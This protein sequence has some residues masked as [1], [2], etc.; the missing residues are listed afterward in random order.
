MRAAL[1]VVLAQTAAAWYGA[2]FIWTMQMLNYPLLSRVGEPSFSA[3]ETAH[4]Q[5]FVV[6]VA[7]GVVVAL[8]TTVLLF[9]VRPP[10]IPIAAPIASATLIVAIIVSTVLFQAP[11]HG[12]LA[13][14]FDATVHA[15]LVNTNWIRTVAWTALA[16]LD[17]W[18]LYLL[19]D[20]AGTARQR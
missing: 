5:R 8:V 3:Y 13:A 2:G 1:L 10:A 4:N 11:A 7:P 14:G 20:G 17:L 16:M 9:F 18:L 15:T 19:F 12:R 6:V